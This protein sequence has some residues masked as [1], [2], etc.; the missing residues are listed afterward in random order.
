MS[1]VKR[2]QWSPESMEAAVNS[3]RDESTSLR[4]AAR[5][6]N[7]PVETLRRR[8]TG[9]VEMNCKPGPPTILTS[10]EEDLLA[11]YLV[12][13]AD[14]GFGLSREDVMAM[15]FNIAEKTKKAHPFK[16][17]FAGRGWYDGFIFRHPKL[18]L[19][20]PQPLSYCRA[21]C[22]N[23]A[24][25]DD[26][27]AKLGGV[28]GRLNLISKPMQI[29]NA[30]ET[31]VGIVHKPGKVVTEIGRRNVYGIAAAEKGKTHTILSCVSASGVTL[32]PL[33]IYPRKKCVPEKMK[34]GAVSG[35]L[36]L[37]S[38][39]GWIN[40]ELY[41]LWFRQFLQWIPPVRPVLLIQDGHSSHVTI[42]LIELARAND[43]HLLC[44]PA[45]T[46]HILQPLD[47]GVFKSFKSHF[48]KA[49]HRYMMKF[50]GRV[51]T[52]DSISSLV[53]EAWPHAFTPLNV[54]GGF[55]KCGIYPFN[56]GQI[57]DRQ[58]APSKGVTPVIPELT[59]EVPLT[60]PAEPSVP[61]F[62]PEEEA[63]YKR[64]YEE[65]YNIDD[66]AYVAWL[67]INHP[68]Y[69]T[70][71]T[72]TSSSYASANVSS[73]STS[74]EDI[75]VLPKPLAKSGGMKRKPALTHKSVCITEE[76]I[77]DELKQN[78]ADK[79]ASEAAKVQKK[80]EREEK[81]KQRK[82]IRR[83]EKRT[84]TETTAAEERKTGKKGKRG[85]KTE[86]KN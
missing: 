74:F 42:E 9:I 63:L 66:P 43:I 64:R 25:I 44:L 23:K 46:T 27:F 61:L 8:V 29:F 10:E 3:V 24:T 80:I 12:D 69:P 30:D 39:S 11:Q 58:T 45:H 36:F 17:G 56:P 2:K 78:E 67:K 31:G 49:C 34:E 83:E 35:T 48:S 72:S 7:V 33:M 62:S 5:L 21:L 65:G 85:E 16:G 75:L 84:G 1:V 37:T 26:F 81:Q 79:Q 82:R 15:A 28:Y 47:V 77:L 76:E 52:S 4:E 20:S 6:Y 54:L 59:P 57:S 55:K 70:S 68:T 14:M 60:P 51:V 13:I 71:V 38:E 19:R 86:E 22:S 41:L 73:P 18:T 32:P 40:R 50:P 53:G